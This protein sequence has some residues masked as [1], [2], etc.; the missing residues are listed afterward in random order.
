MIF[1]MMA[2]HDTTSITTAM[3]AYYLAVRPEWQ[4]RLRAAQVEVIAV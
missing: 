2:A 3:L 1:L 4:E